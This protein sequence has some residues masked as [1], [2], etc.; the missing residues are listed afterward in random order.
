MPFELRLAYPSPKRLGTIYNKQTQ[1]NHCDAHIVWDRWPS[2]IYLAIPC[3]FD[4][5]YDHDLHVS[6]FC[7]GEDCNDSDPLIY[8][9]NP[10]P[11]CAC[12]EPYPEGTDEICGDGIDND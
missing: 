7:G 11:Y 12:E 5:D 2:Q 1:K 10:N 6:A 9:T 3:S 8:P 4:N